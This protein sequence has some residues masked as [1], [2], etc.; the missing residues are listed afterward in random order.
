M[1]PSPLS[2]FY[3]SK[4]LIW[5]SKQALSLAALRSSSL[6]LYISTAMFSRKKPSDSSTSSRW[7]SAQSQSLCTTLSA[8][9][10]LEHC[11]VDRPS[12]RWHHLYCKSAKFDGPCIGPQ[13]GLS[14]FSEER[15]LRTIRHWS[16][17][18]IFIQRVS[19]WVAQTFSL[20]ATVHILT[21]SLLRLHPKLILSRPSQCMHKIRISHELLIYLSFSTRRRSFQC[22]T[23]SFCYTNLFISNMQK[24]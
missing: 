20:T 7:T 17:E 4:T 15:R 21:D 1:T 10:H 24:S 23:R 11:E 13:E 3:T 22:E 5:S 9:E 19:Q 16:V 14:W 6:R 12:S 18:R 2:T 8:C